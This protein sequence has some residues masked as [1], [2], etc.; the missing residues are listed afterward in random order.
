[1]LPAHEMGPLYISAKGNT[2]GDTRAASERHISYLI[3]Q[4]ELRYGNFVKDEVIAKDTKFYE[5]HNP[6]WI[7]LIG[8][9]SFL[10]VWL[11]LD[12]VPGVNWKRIDVTIT[13]LFL[14]H[15]LCWAIVFIST[16]GALY[17]SWSVIDGF[18]T[19]TR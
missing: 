11:L 12:Q 5:G 9:V 14:A 17:R 15:L 3:R 8:V 18:N 4:W 19:I 6:K 2:T 7:G 16:G 13:A 10:L 1:M